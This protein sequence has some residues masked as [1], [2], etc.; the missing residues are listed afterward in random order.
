MFRC[1]LLLSWFYLNDVETDKFVEWL[2][3]YFCIV[4]ILNIDDF[5]VLNP[6]VQQ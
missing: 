4:G 5:M 2:Y 1:H 6:Y 3:I